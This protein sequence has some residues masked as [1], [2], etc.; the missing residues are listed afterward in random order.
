MSVVKVIELVGESRQD[1]QDAVGNAVAEASR[2]IDR[3]S[4]VEVSNWTANVDHGRITEY[5]ANVKVAFQV[6]R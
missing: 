6:E 4:G 5:K 2:T 3:I 1:W